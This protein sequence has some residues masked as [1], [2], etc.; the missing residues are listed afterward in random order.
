MTVQ[1]RDYQSHLVGE[2]RAKWAAGLRRVLAVLPTGGGKTETAISLIES[3]ATPSTRVL[4][5]VE[6]KTLAVQW[7]ARLRR[8]GMTVVGLLQ[9]ENSIRLS[10]TVVV[11]TAQSLRT[12]GAP[13]GVSLVVVDESHIWHQTHD[14][15]LRR[16]PEVRVLGLTA[17]PLREGLGTRFDTVVVGATI[18]DLIG[19]GQLVRPRYFSPS[20]GAIENALKGVKMQAGDYATSDLAN[21]MRGKAILGDVISTWLRLGENRQTIA[22]CVDK[23]H[24]REMADEFVAV[25]IPAAVVLDDTEDDHRARLFAEFDAKALRV[26]VSVGVLSIGFD[27]PVASCAIMARPTMSLSLYLQQGGRVLRPCDGKSDALLLDHAA[28]VLTH[29]R[30]EDFDPPCDLS[31]IDKRTD[32]KKRRDPYTGWVCKH[33]EATNAISD[34]ICVECGA[35]RWN[36]TAV[37]ILDGELQN[38]GVAHNDVTLPGPTKSDVKMFYRQCKWYGSSKGMS[39][40]LGWAYHAVRRRFHLDE[41]TARRLIPWEWRGLSALAPEGEAAR[42]FRADLQRVKIAG[43]FRQRKGNHGGKLLSLGQH[44]RG[45]QVLPTEDRGKRKEDF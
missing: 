12:R 36:R 10:A 23:Q 40:P 1:L 24:A 27:S 44:S 38:V 16:L 11:A 29:G 18:R 6:R 5:I 35:P 7:V 14:S 41:A 4:I 34:D 22:F 21:A 13:E 26:L 33:C 8:H 3:E 19:T 37:V 42:W 20:A 25:G 32:R 31:K 17:T 45:T 28:N 2:V 39:N 30:L 15:V 43:H 9:G